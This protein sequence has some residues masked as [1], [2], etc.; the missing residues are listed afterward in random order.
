[1]RSFH[2]ILVWVEYFIDIKAISCVK[3]IS[4]CVL[5]CRIHISTL[6]V[7]PCI[8]FVHFT[9]ECSYEDLGLD[10]CGKT[11]SLRAHIDA[12]YHLAANYNQQLQDASVMYGAARRVMMDQHNY[13]YNSRGHYSPCCKVELPESTFD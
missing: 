2:D 7:A 13:K 8:K 5:C 12:F 10:N 4:S 6:I 1:M 3:V 11:Q 9:I